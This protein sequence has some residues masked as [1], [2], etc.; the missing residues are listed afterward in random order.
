MLARSV[1][2]AGVELG[3]KQQLDAFKEKL[4]ENPKDGLD[5]I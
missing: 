1:A 4:D 2:P 5:S 3:Q